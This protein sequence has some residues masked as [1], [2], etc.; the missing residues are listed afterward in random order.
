M[1]P[2]SST[3][4][5]PLDPSP[6]E[7]LLEIHQKL[8]GRSDLI[9]TIFRAVNLTVEDFSD[10]QLELE[11]LN[12]SRSSESYVAGAVI[13]IK[14]AF[15]KSKNTMD[16]DAAGQLAHSDTDSNEIVDTSLEPPTPDDS[17][18]VDSTEDLDDAAKLSKGPTAVFPCVIRY[19]DLTAAG[20]RHLRR[21]PKLMLIRD[22]WQTMMDIINNRVKGVDGGAII[23]G[24]PGIGEHLLLLLT[25]SAYTNLFSKAKR[26][27]CI[28]SSSVA[29]LKP[30]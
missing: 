6:P 27:F 5:D 15:L 8:W 11:R 4:A 24:Q 10:L 18:D 25:L 21:V 29:S 20:L 1:G 23:T 3:G 14:S 2:R 22:E 26:V 16:F 17:M 19:M 12:P 30:S 7:W 9:D 13:D 28:I